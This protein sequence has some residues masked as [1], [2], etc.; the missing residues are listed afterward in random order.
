[1]NE[2]RNNEKINDEY[3]KAAKIDYVLIE[4]EREVMKK[5]TKK[6]NHVTKYLK[7]TKMIAY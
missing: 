1:M 6:N 5:K 4:P 7:V 3:L 2:R